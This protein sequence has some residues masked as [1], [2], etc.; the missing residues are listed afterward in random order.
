MLVLLQI[1]GVEEKGFIEADWDVLKEIQTFRKGNYLNE[2]D[3]A[4]PG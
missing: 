4:C 2:I 1:W 3:Q